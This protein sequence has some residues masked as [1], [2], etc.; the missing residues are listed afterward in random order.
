MEAALVERWL[1][2]DG[3]VA[4]GLETFELRPQQVEMARAVAAALAEPHHLAVE[5]GTGVGKTFAYLLPAI[6][7]ITQNKRRVVVSTHTIALQEQLMQKDIPFLQRVLGESAA[8][9]PVAFRA[10][11]VKGRNN[12][13]SLRRLKSAS[14]RTNT[15]LANPEQR[16][17]LRLI[18][19]W[20]SETKD[21]SLSDLPQT[22]P[23]EIWE[24]VRSEHNNCLGRRC[25]DYLA[26]FFQL[27]RLRAEQA[28]LLVVN[29]ALLVS[30][31]VLRQANASVLPDYDMVII[32]EAHTLE[33]VTTGQIGVSVS[34]ASVHH[35]LS[36]LF[37]ERT[38]K[39][40]LATLG[41]ASQIRKVLE[42]QSA[43]TRFFERLCD[44][45]RSCGRANGRLVAPPDVPNDLSAALMALAGELE[46]LKPTLRHESDRYELGA[47]IERAKALADALDSILRQRYADHVYWI[48]I[49][50]EPSPRVTINAA[51]L[52]VGPFLR[53]HLFQQAQSAIL[54]SATLATDAAGDF[55]YL[56]GR[57]GLP[58][59]RTLR[60]GSPYD[61][62]RQVTLHIETGLP[63]PNDYAEFVRAAAAATIHYLRQTE[64]R[65]FVLL[66]SYRMLNDLARLVQE[67]LRAEGYTILVHGQSLSRSRMLEKFR[68]TTRAVLFGTDSFWQG[69]DVAGEALSNVTIV[70]LP[71]A[72]PDRPLVEA[73][74]EQIRRQ[75]GNPFNDY[76][77][78]EAVL[79]FR[80]GFGR[81]IRSKS[82][83]GIVV[84]LDSR[85]ARKPYGRRFLDSLPR[86]RIEKSTRPW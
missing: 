55:D 71:F 20:A 67:E 36:S 29:H 45:Q 84:V 62:S 78:P 42:A 8:P 63:D 48:D 30:D 18:E 69:V 27:A 33:Q 7:E 77:L 75:G 26:C 3:P 61:Y 65:A 6:A 2:P 56:L 32:D 85:I 59:A 10:E 47:Q 16:A 31:L 41:S 70:R 52:D 46:V 34:S 49:D 1:A 72:V 38:G 44:W 9:L 24:K 4:R 81:L 13:L 22:P 11:L 39:G 79:K 23:P 54:T 28:D 58:E 51:P 74:I 60:L 43:A 19:E 5:A 12:Y 64:G 17:A 76:Q 80:Q 68:A 25:P 83:T 14:R 50:N 82:D 15:L 40:Y 73:R 66:T 86:C 57:L 21:G 35:L 37:N 53:E